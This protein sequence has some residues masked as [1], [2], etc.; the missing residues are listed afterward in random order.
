[1][2]KIVLD[3]C[4]GTG[5]WSKPY[6]E[7]GYDIRLIT[8]PKQDVRDYIPPDIEFVCRACN[9]LKGE[10]NPEQYINNRKRLNLRKQKMEYWKAKKSS[11][12]DEAV[13]DAYMGIFKMRDTKND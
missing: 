11:K 2:K 13:R 9:F 5:S 1:M 7:A 12:R 4:G 3:L 8:L 6:K 10:M